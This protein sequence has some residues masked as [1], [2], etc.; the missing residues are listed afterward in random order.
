MNPAIAHLLRQLADACDAASGSSMVTPKVDAGIVED[1]NA[2]K[3]RL[4]RE[5]QARYRA[6]HVT[7]G[8]VTDSV[9]RNAAG[10]DSVTLS[11]TRNAGGEG[12]V[13]LSGSSSGGQESKANTEESNAHA[14]GE[15]VTRDVTR[16]AKPSRVTRNAKRD[17]V[18]P[19]FARFWQAWP[20]S[21]RK[22]ARVQCLAKW[23]AMNLEPLADQI[24]AAVQHFAR[25][26]EWTKDGGQFIP[27][28]L[29]WL[30]Q[31][32][33]EAVDTTKGVAMDPASRQRAEQFIV[34]W[35]RMDADAR[36][37]LATEAGLTVARIDESVRWQQPAQA[38]VTA[39]DKS[40]GAAA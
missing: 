20:K 13:L 39:W 4:A 29:V 7:L 38:A 36:S 30:N 28:P 40:K 15:N 6:R 37:A 10:R 32:R 24:I 12:G 19:G 25:S 16:N 27:A 21:L 17:E 1:A 11:V 3:R 9:T 14:R 34:A 35:K 2:R 5:R 33:W 23:Q 22:A 31:R 8:S 18:T 26:P